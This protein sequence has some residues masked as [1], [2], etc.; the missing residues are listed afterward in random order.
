MTAAPEL[1]ERFAR[2]PEFAASPLYR[3]MGN[4]VSGSTKM[5]AMAS[6]CRGGQ[7]PTFLFFGAIHYL[8][9]KGAEHPLKSYYGSIVGEKSGPPDDRLS[10]ILES[11]CEEF[12][13]EL[14]SLVETRLVQTNAVRRSLVL[15][16]GVAALAFRTEQPLHVIEI[17]ASAGINLRFD[18]YGY[19]VGDQVFGDRTS[20]VQI[21]AEC[22]GRIPD[23]DRLPPI[24]SVTGIDLN[25]LDAANEEDQRWLKALVWPDNRDEARLLE[26]ALPVV[27]DDP[28]SI[29][30]GDAIEVCPMVAAGLPQGEPRLVFEIAT[31]MHVRQEQ[32]P[33]FDDAI[34]SFGEAGPLYTLSLAQHQS[35][36]RPKPARAGSAVALTMP[37]GGIENLAVVGDR[38]TWIESVPRRMS[39]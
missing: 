28:P 8:L 35:A 21:M 7:Y 34:A 32:R 27:A 17:G 5:L 36:Q 18:R 2:V 25:P 4:A 23:L 29:V 31:K 16:V 24:G 11:F 1:A 10:E 9:L 13:T 19:Q 15:R 37:D 39:E 22:N 33:A 26:S 20:P 3:A 12:E 38:I 6:R 14:V 30:M